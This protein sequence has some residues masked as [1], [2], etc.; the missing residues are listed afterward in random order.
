MREIRGRE[1]GDLTLFCIVFSQVWREKI[2]SI[3]KRLQQSHSLKELQTRTTYTQ[4]PN[5]G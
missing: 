4:L 2:P 1:E 3:V 5:K